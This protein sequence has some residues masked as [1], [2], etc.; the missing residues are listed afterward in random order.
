MVFGIYLRAFRTEDA[1]FINALRRIEAMENK[2]GG[3]K[4]FVSPERELKWVQDIIQGDNPSAV[5]LAICENG[6]DGIIGYTSIA[7]IDYRNGSCFWSGIKLAPEKSG[8]GYG[9]QTALMILK[10]V[11]EELR[12]VRCIGHALEEHGV[13]IKLMEKAGFRKEGLMRNYVYKNGEHKNTWLLS[14]LQEEYI[15]VKQRYELEP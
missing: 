7:D 11:F 2:I 10:Y 5:Y 14:I 13:A 1:L 9:L 6:N 8:K 3:V 15:Q 12:M 4:R